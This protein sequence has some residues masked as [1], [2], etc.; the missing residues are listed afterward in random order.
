MSHTKTKC[1]TSTL[2]VRPVF[3]TSAHLRGILTRK[4]LTTLNWR[5]MMKHDP[6]DYW[7]APG[8]GWRIALLLVLVA[9]CILDLF[10]WRPYG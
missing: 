7:S 3:A 5:V 2:S 6:F 1:T 4:T 8:R 10:L 9:I